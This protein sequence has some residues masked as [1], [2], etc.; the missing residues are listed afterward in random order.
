MKNYLYK[1]W[2]DSTYFLA[3]GIT[4]LLLSFLST[5]PWVLFLIWL[6]FPVY[7]IHQGEEHFY[8]GGFKN[9]VNQEVFQSKVKDFPLNDAN[10]FWINILA[11]WILFPCSAILAQ[12]VSLQFGVL[13]PIFGLFNA[14]LHILSWIIKQRY[15]PGLI[16]SVC[17][18]YPTGILTLYLMRQ[19]DLITTTNVFLSLVLTVILHLLIVGIILAKLYYKKIPTS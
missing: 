2:A 1:H 14:T 18:N 7:L 17:L 5:T 9:T 12:H 11:I 6:Q 15:N 8:P 4:I 10:I 13:L 16:A 3:I 19:G